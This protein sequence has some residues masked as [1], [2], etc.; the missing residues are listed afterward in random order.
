MNLYTRILRPLLFRL[1]PECA[2]KLML[3]LLQAAGVVPG[4]PALL[5][6]QFSTSAANPVQVFGLRFAN[7]LGLAAGYDKDGQALTGLACLGFGHLEVGTVTPEPQPGNP[8]PRIFRLPQDEAL[9]NCMGFPNAGAAALLQRLKGA[10]ER[11]FILGIN[12]GKGV[13]TP[14]EVA[15]MDYLHL[16]E[17]FYDVADYLVVNVSSPNTLGLRRLQ[18]RKSLDSLLGELAQ[19]RSACVFGGAPRRPLLVKLAPD[20]D[21]EELE[22]ALAAIER[23]GIDGVI[24]SNTTIERSMLKDP[25]RTESGGL[26]GAPL[27]IRST[28]MVRDIVRISGGRLPVIATGGVLNA[29]DVRAKLDAGASLVQVYTGLVYRGP[30]LAKSILQALTAE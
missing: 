3:T 21:L 16:L 20:L 25:A 30:G 18:A 15:A 26:S 10:A 9:I 1:D 12:M 11:S 28:Q 19:A 24:A 22:D 27:R 23:N 4:M 6:W 29:E 8:R 2:H 7:P 5:R 13:A 17:M 14:L